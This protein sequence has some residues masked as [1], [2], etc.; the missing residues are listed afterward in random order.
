MLMVVFGA[1][2]S[3]DSTPVYPVASG[4]LAW[5]PPLARELFDFRQEFF[6]AL[7]EFPQ[8]S[9]IIG[10]LRNLP[11]GVSLE[12]KLSMLQAQLPE[13]PH[14]ARQLTAVRF[15]LRRVLW[16]HGDRWASQS[17]GSSNYAALLGQLQD[18]QAR[19]EEAVAL[20]SFNYD[21]LLERAYTSVFDRDPSQGDS[22]DLEAYV[23]DGAFPIFK[24]HGSVNWSR[25]I[26]DSHAMFTPQINATA[27]I[28]RAHEIHASERFEVT[29]QL[30]Q[31]WARSDQQQ[32]LFPA[33]AIPT[34]VKSVFEFPKLHRD[35]LLELLPKVDRLLTVGWR[36]SEG[37]FLD[38]WGSERK[39]HIRVH[40]VSP[41]DGAGVEA[42][43]RSAGFDGPHSISGMG[44]T[45]FAT[46]GRVEQILT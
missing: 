23:S 3:Y 2:A 16:E 10:D 28:S 14:R 44:F 17:H 39:T 4:S 9:A 46:S 7:D 24:P 29:W 21:T 41:T 38:Q 13:L 33:L 34:D 20:V 35:R 42:N 43:L 31:A 11:A 26:D 19:S 37:T 27:I 32:A 5:R 8:F 40:I 25:W 18:W 36:A 12:S 1:G 15:Y 30:D 6:A 22:P 45:E